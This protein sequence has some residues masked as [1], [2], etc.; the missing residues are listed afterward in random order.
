VITLAQLG[1][2]GLRRRIE[3][4]N[5]EEMGGLVTGNAGTDIPQ[6]LP[7][8]LG[9]GGALSRKEG[10]KQR[11]WIELELHA[12]L[13]RGEVHRVYKS[14][15]G[16]RLVSDHVRTTRNVL[17]R[18][19]NAL[20]VAYELEPLRRVTRASQRL[21]RAYTASIIEEARFNESAERWA[22]LAFIQNVIHVIPIVTGD[23]PRNRQLEFDVV[24]P[25][26]A[27]VII[28]KGDTD[29]SIL[30]YLSDGDG[31]S[32]VAVDNERFWYLDKGYQIVREIVHGYRNLKG[33][34]MQPW[35]QWRTRP[36]TRDEDYWKR[37]EGQAMVDATLAVGVVNAA[38]YAIRQN[39]N[40]KMP[41]LVARNIDQDVPAGQALT[42]EKPIMLRGGT[43]DVADLI[44]PVKEFLDQMNDEQGEIAED[45]GVP[46]GVI[47][48]SRSSDP[49]R[50]F[51]A[52][53]RQRGR[54]TKQLRHA[55][56][57][58][59]IKAAI[60]MRA[61]GHP[62]AR[63]IDPE[64]F[65]RGLEV[66]FQA[67]T[68]LERP[69]ERLEFY[70]KALSLGILDHVMVRMLEHPDEPFGV[71]EAHVRESIE[72]RNEFAG[73]LAARNLPANA[74][75]DFDT[76]QQLQ[77]RLG[78]MSRQPTPPEGSTPP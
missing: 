30:V 75:Q 59:Q 52:I 1:P 7:G 5:L 25:F 10:S 18:T 11:S 27:D 44:T 43:F 20:S 37:G 45:Y 60:I 47:D 22:R 73:L 66:K 3:A 17:K 74:G 12:G 76:V 9:P 16:R 62:A 41:T 67:A 4:D 26:A 63:E 48:G 57:E 14:E 58:T 34:P 46:V 6:I 54:Q 64:L 39:S 55:D 33:R 23:S 19:A 24:Q 8:A 49:W 36:R 13:I 35:I 71:A 21:N 77:G 65:A 68:F 40:R 31:F 32:R 56:L 2:E 53:A 42:G 61:E 38:M 15:D 70:E 72:R 28:D 69:R 50:E 29:P 51:Q 78:G